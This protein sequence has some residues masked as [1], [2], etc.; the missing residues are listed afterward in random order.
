VISTILRLLHLLKALGVLLP[1]S[2][3]ELVPP[4]HIMNP[5]LDDQ[6]RAVI[7]I[8][9]SERKYVHDLEVLQVSFLTTAP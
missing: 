1:P 7:E 5:A 6:T 4:S 3:D 2:V 8:I 9:D